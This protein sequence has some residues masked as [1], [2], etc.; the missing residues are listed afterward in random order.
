MSV[1]A[2]RG[3]ADDCTG[4]AGHVAPVVDRNRCEAKAACVQVCPFE[5]FA[6]LPLDTVDRAALTLRG[7]VKAWVHGNR[8]AYVVRAPDCHACGLCV[9]ACPEQAIRLEAASGPAG[10]PR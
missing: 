5:V 8:Q 7:K 9:R 4:E 2:G 10:N 6:I 1:A 3:R